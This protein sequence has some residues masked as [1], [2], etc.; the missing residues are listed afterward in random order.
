MNPGCKNNLF[1]P[2][3][4]GCGENGGQAEVRVHK[5]S[6]IYINID[7]DFPTR[8]EELEVSWRPGRSHEWIHLGAIREEG[9]EGP[10]SYLK[11][12]LFRE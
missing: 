2:F 4:I 6:G 12:L 1:L 11:C 3:S 5:V 7:T 8:I 10:H 9:R